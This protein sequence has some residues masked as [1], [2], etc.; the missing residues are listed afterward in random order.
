MSGTIPL[1]VPHHAS[2]SSAPFHRIRSN[3]AKFDQELTQMT[4]NYEDKIRELE[5][6]LAALKRTL[7]EYPNVCMA[8]AA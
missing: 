1:P 7:E 2:P 4:N 5:D 6:E 8:H 3:R